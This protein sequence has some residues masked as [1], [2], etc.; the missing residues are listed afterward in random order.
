MGS[1]VSDRGE[2]EE[3]EGRAPGSLPNLVTLTTLPCHSWVCGSVIGRFWVAL[4]QSLGGHGQM[5]AEL[6]AG[7][8]EPGAA[9]GWPVCQGLPRWPPRCHVPGG[10]E[11]SRPEVQSLQTRAHLPRSPHKPL[12][13]QPSSRVAFHRALHVD[14]SQQLPHCCSFYVLIKV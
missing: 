4:A 13:P 6:E 5:L 12:K 7:G 2:A 1:S 9:G 14:L 11:R 8:G 3:D 10:S